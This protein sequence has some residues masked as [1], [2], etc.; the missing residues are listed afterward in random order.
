MGGAGGAD[1]P[2]VLHQFMDTNNA[3][4]DV[5]GPHIHHHHHYHHACRLE[6]AKAKTEDNN[7]DRL[8]GGTL[9]S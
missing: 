6:N 1:V 8:I 4:N 2:A 5:D 3:M 9:A 7:H